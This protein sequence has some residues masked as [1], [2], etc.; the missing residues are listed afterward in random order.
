[1]KKSA[2]LFASLFILFTM[3]GCEDSNNPAKSGICFE[4]GEKLLYARPPKY[5]EA[6][7]KFTEAIKYDKNNFEAYYLRGCAKM[8]IAINKLQVKTKEAIT[9]F[10]DAIADFKKATELKPNYADAYFNIG[11]CYYYMHD[12]EKS[13]EYYK[14]AEKYG[15]PNLEDKLRRCN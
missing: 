8:N 5:K 3:V 9:D 13:C 15:R 2:W 10:N 14:L 11:S 6:V 12:E 7:E 4:E 1:M